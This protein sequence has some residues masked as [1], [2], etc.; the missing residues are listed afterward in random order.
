MDRASRGCKC[1]VVTARAASPPPSSKARLL[2]LLDFLP[3]F[4]L[5]VFSLLYF[6]ITMSREWAALGAQLPSARTGFESFPRARSLLCVFAVLSD[7]L[8]L[9]RV[10]RAYASNQSSVI[11]VLSSRGGCISSLGSPEGNPLLGSFILV[12]C[13]GSTAASC[14]LSTP[15]AE[16][17]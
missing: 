8:W 10:P 17:V 4:L 13:G 1:P 11:C 16:S 14:A 7:G 12:P 5:F 2:A 9:H 3:F 6:N 15:G